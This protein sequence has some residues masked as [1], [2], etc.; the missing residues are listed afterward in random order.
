MDALATLKTLAAEFELQAEKGSRTA[1]E[2][3]DLVRGLRKE[4]ASLIRQREELVSLYDVSRDLTSANSLDELLQS[5]VD[6]ALVLVKGERGFVVLLDP[7]GAQNIAAARR[8]EQGEVAE[9]DEAFS[10]SLVAQVIRSHEPILTTN[11]QD[12]ARF[13]LSQSIILQ[14]IR[15]V[16]AV[17]L[18]ARGDLQ[19]AIYVDTR[20]S[21]RPFDER[22]LKLLQTMASQAALAIKST[23]LLADVVA[24]N[25]KLSAALVELQNTQEQL[26]QAERLAAVGR[27]AA[28]VAHELRSPLTIM[29]NSVYYLDRLASM[30]KL[31][32][33]TVVQRYLQKIDDEVERQNKII[34]D[35]LFF[36]R[37]R[38]R[39]LT[40]VDLNGILQETVLRVRMPEAVALTLDLCE[41]LEPIRADADQLTQVFVNLATNAVQAM[42][43]GGT[44]AISCTSEEPYAVVRVRDT[45][46]GIAPD[47]LNSLFE[48]FFTTKEKGIGLGLSVTKSIVEA[49]RGRIEVAST[50][51]VG[52]TFSVW[53]PLELI[54]G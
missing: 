18:L 36:S 12:D 5:I 51:G 17:P 52:T 26:V 44:L 22:D 19:G 34:N 14:D 47:A 31:D 7:Q 1:P 54:G 39:K 28:S 16:L 40:E 45:G 24:S 23:R 43:Q 33:V 11:V 27:L 50:L 38:P 21:Q 9:T 29:R 35:L 10:S 4:F 25:E 6:K 2:M 13:A 32:S 42:P 49:H 20:M 30:G 48:P 46:T 3:S 8:F 41:G 15:S 37:N 53:L